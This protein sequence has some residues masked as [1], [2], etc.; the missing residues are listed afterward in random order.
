M[1]GTSSTLVHEDTGT[2]SGNEWK[3]ISFVVII[4]LVVM[5]S[6]IALLFI[7]THRRGQVAIFGEISFLQS[8]TV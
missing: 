2:I 3:T 1:K 6:T 4:L 8:I 7:F 5:F